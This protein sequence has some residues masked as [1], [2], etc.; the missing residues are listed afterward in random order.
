M[1]KVTMIIGILILAGLVAVPVM[2]WG[3]QMGWGNHMMGYWGS[4]PGYGRGDYGD[5]TADQKRKL[6]DLDR[7]FFDETKDLRD[8]NRAKSVEL[9]AIL[10]S[11]SPDLEKAKAIQSEISDLR[12]GIDE[13][14]LTYELE[15]RKILP[16]QRFAGNEGWY[17]HHMG[18]YGHMMGNGP[19][20]CWN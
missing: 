4:G 16:D 15:A 3:P 7:R 12:A 19:G 18:G 9:D 5:L 14:T 6:E 13:K 10:N 11:T 8:Q 1:K 20:Y 2:A 17:G